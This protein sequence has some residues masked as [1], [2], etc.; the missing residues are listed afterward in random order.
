MT[1]GTRKRRSVFSQLNSAQ[2]AKIKPY[3]I[4][5]TERTD[6][7]RL[8]LLFPGGFVFTVV[9]RQRRHHERDAR[10][11]AVHLENDREQRARDEGAA[12]G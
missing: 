4:P 1:S 9:V 2:P 12:H 6:P 3:K 8:K 5:Q 11:E 7:S 10:S